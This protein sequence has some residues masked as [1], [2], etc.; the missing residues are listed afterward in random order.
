M[1]NYKNSFLKWRS[2][3]VNECDFR[4]NLENLEGFLEELS[5]LVWVSL[6]I[7]S[8]DPNLKLPF[9]G[10]KKIH[11]IYILSFVYFSLWRYLFLFCYRFQFIFLLYPSRIYIRMLFWMIFTS[12]LKVREFFFYIRL[13]YIQV[14]CVRDK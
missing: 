10:S 14:F 4:G 1:K 9:Y 6:E 12:V 13:M 3:S 8:L 5:S 7:S 2:Y 11:K